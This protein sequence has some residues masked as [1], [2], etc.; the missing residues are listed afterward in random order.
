MEG[1]GQWSIVNSPR[2]TAQHTCKCNRMVILRLD[3]RIQYCFMDPAIKSQ[4]DKLCIVISKVAVRLRNL[5]RFLPSVEMTN[6][7]TNKRKWRAT[8]RR[9]RKMHASAV[10]E[11]FCGLTTESSIVFMDPAIKSQEDKLCL[12]FFV[13]FVLFLRALRGERNRVQGTGSPRHPVSC[14]LHH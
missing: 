4:N 8:L 7:V 3:H 6:C 2:S 9:G 1:Q 14:I 10:R 11:S 5:I 12:F 13:F